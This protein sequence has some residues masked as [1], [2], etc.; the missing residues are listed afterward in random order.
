MKNDGLILKT[1]GAELF[2]LS[3]GMFFYAELIR[4]MRKE[5]MKTWKARE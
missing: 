5:I 4:E 2:F 3:M 1:Y